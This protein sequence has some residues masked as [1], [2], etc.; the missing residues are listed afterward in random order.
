MS[1][2]YRKVSRRYTNGRTSSAYSLLNSQAVTL[3]RVSGYSTLR[4]TWRSKKENS[5]GIAALRDR[6][7]PFWLTCGTLL[8]KGCSSSVPADFRR[9][10]SIMRLV[11]HSLPTNRYN[12]GSKYQQ[13][14]MLH[15][16]FRYIIYI[17]SHS[18]SVVLSL[19][20][21]DRIRSPGS[22]G[23]SALFTISKFRKLLA[24]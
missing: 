5:V 9:S 12:L 22:S 21:A 8:W 11:I 4:E 20:C 15:G 23:L 24:R 14:A 2:Y 3:Y 19:G 17:S 1:W 10:Y 18:P 7:P 13:N 16:A 6:V